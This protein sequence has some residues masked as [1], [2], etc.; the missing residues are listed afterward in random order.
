MLSRGHRLASQ[1]VPLGGVDLLVDSPIPVGPTLCDRSPAVHG[2][3]AMSVGA[4]SPAVEAVSRTT[5]TLRSIAAG[6]PAVNRN[7][8]STK[9]TS[10]PNIPSTAMAGMNRENEVKLPFRNLD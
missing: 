6:R 10:Q 3:L 8:A 1:G 9:A 2:P 7:L 5:E 4:R